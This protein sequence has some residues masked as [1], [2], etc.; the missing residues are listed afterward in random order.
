MVAEPRDGAGATAG[1]DGHS[2]CFCV[3][4]IVVVAIKDVGAAPGAAPAGVTGCANAGGVGAGA[5]W[6][7]EASSGE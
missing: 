1:A 7:E 2:G 4:V 3:A 5:G 6:S